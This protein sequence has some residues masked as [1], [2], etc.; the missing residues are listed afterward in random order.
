[1]KRKA[2]ASQTETLGERQVRVVCSTP[3]VDRAGEVVVQEGLDFSHYMANPVVLFAHDPAQPIARAVRLGLEGGNLV[4]TVQFPPAAVSA[5][6]DEV[7]GLIQAGVLNTVSL[8]FAPLEVEPMDPALPKGPVRYL[9]GELLE[10]S[11]VAVPA[12]RGATIVARQHAAARV[13]VVRSLYDAGELARVLCNLGWITDAAK[14]EAEIEADGS[15][16]PAMLG[17]AMQQLGAALVAMT[18]EEVAEMLAEAGLDAADTAALAPAEV[19]VVQA[20]ALPLVRKFRAG[21]ARGR[22]ASTKHAALAGAAQAP[23]AVGKAA[24][25][26]S[27]GREQRRR[28]VQAIA[29]G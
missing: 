21:W 28:L 25:G 14:Y 13:V 2:Y 5:K 24:H 1:M 9:A 3:D 8:G 29:L 22:R 15:R 10:L 18:A 4:A 27:A 26:A 7:Y 19:E 16:V 12:N 23:A 20:A 17:E 11:F 6:A